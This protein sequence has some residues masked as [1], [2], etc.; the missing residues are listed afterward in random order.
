L[1]DAFAANFTAN[2]DVGA[3]VAVVRHGELVTDL[4]GGFVDPECTTPGRATPSS[5]C[6][7]PRR[8]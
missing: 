2:G 6:F 3:S 8:P 5:T 1:K 4:W 7:R